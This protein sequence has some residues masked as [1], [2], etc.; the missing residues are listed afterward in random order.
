MAYHV[1]SDKPYFDLIIGDKTFS[2]WSMRAWLVAVQSGL[3]FREI[4]ITLD[5]PKTAEQIAKFSPSGKVPAL[6]QGKIILWDSL[7]IA[8][9][10]N[11]LS[12][13][14]KLWPEDIGARALARTYAAEVHSGFASLRS[15]LSMDLK[16][17]EEVRHLTP[18]T[19]ADINRIL[20]MWTNALKVSEGPYL[21]G[22]FSIADAFFAPIVFRFLS[23]KIQIKDK[24]AKAYMKNI[25]DHH[26]VQFWVEEAMKEKTPRKVF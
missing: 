11:E 4:N 14:A 6:K 7:A 23:Y 25:Q 13:E 2:S 12:P 22:D 5:Q 1:H 8:E 18:G 16:H 20:E 26:G 15:Q 3:P 24:M 21:F 19:I 9:Y 17:T 10:L